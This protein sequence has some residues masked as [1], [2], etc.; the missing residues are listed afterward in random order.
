MKNMILAASLVFGVFALAAQTQTK[1]AVPSIA[2]LERREA[3]T[4]L[5]VDGKPFLVL[6]GELANTASSNTEFMK[7]VWPALANKAHLNTVLTG[8]SW[9][10]IEPE[11]GKYD[12]RFVDEAIANAQRKPGT[13]GPRPFMRSETHE[14][15]SRIGQRQVCE[16]G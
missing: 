16:R 1:P 6:S 15:H 14:R 8:V 4:Q 13:A 2:R 11:E 12:F 3:A 7:A 10:W 5:I 9:D